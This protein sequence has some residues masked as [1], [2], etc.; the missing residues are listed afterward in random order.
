MRDDRDSQADFIAEG[1]QA[2]PVTSPPQQGD[3]PDVKQLMFCPLPTTPGTELCSEIV[4]NQLVRK[5]WSGLN[6]SCLKRK[7]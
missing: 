5:K 6:N 1:T 4:M 7:K 2:H 3:G